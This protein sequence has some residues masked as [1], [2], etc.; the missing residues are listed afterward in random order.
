MAESNRLVFYSRCKPQDCDAL[1]IALDNKIIFVGY[2]LWQVSVAYDP[3]GLANCLVHPGLDYEEWDRCRKAISPSAQYMKNR[4]LVREVGPGS[5][6][7]IPR[8]EFGAVYAATVESMFEVV[9]DPPWYKQY[10]SLRGGEDDDASRH[11]GDIA[12]VWRVSDYV[13]IP[14]PDIPGWLR[15]SLFGQSTF[16]RI[17]GNQDIGLDPFTTM[18]TIMNLEA[19][20]SLPWTVE[21]SQVSARLSMYMT[22][23]N[24]E[25]LVVSLFTA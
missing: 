14:I 16:A 4:N 6:A 22:P 20:G 11:A 18:S 12:Q 19:R 3:H 7:L 23:S 9:N 10:I 25:H 17:H 2:P 5:I 21:P 1:E 13:K 15:G 8:P 24:L